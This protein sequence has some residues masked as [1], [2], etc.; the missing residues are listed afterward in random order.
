MNKVPQGLV[1]MAVRMALLGLTL[2]IGAAQSVSWADCCCGSFCQH[3]NACDGCG[4]EEACSA[5]LG[6]PEERSGP[7]C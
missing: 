4:S 2:L 5:A 1:S 6:T 3:K 7:G